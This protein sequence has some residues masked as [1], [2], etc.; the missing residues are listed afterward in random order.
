M[1]TENI[2]K[3]TKEEINQFKEELKEC[4]KLGGNNVYC[5]LRGVS[6]SG[7]TRYIDFYTFTPNTQGITKFYLTYK[8]CAIL[9]YPLTSDNGLKVEGCGMDMGFAV[10]YDLGRTLYPTGDGKTITGRNGDTEPE[11]DGGYIIKHEWL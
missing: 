6:R 7:M 2:K 5:V 9:G 1:K 10:I 3:H 4:I 11:T 8:I